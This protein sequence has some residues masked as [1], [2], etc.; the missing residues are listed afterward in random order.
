MLRR[1]ISMP[2]ERWTIIKQDQVIDDPY[3]SVTMQQL[4][5]PDGQII[6]NWPYVH[7]RDYVNA[8][9]LDGDGRIMVIE[10]YKHGLGRSSWQVVG[11]YLEPGEEP[12]SAIQ[13][14]LLEETGY[15][16]EEWLDLGLFVMD[17]NRH[18]GVGY[19][20]LARN[21]RKLA[22]PDHDDLEQFVVRWVSQNEL[23]QALFDG[24]VAIISYAVNIALGLLALESE[25]P[26]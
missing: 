19:F 25:N 21:A 16:S 15:R 1:R 24:R 12:L 22:E 13:R 11:G 18:V 2:E 5:L 14:E 23:K 6:S 7:T 8:L 9:V 26:A 3:V 4:Q 20:F 17:A 10:G